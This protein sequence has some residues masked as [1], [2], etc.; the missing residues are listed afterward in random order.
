MQDET[1]SKLMRMIVPCRMTITGVDG[2]WKLSQNKADAVRL[3]AA[4]GVASHGFGAETN[5]IA[6]MMRAAIGG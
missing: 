3:A 4:D 2:T 1:M 6:Q 5:I